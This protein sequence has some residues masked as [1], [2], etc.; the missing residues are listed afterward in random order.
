MK[1][2]FNLPEINAAELVMEDVILASGDIN[3]NFANPDA[4]DQDIV[5]PNPSGGGNTDWL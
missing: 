3:D 5:M 1:K 4:I 2:T